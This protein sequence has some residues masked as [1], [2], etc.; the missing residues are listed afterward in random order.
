MVQRESKPTVL[1]S[2]EYYRGIKSIEFEP[3]K[4]KDFSDKLVYRKGDIR[5]EKRFFKKPKYITVTEDLYKYDGHLVNAKELLNTYCWSIK[6][7]EEKDFFYYPAEVL[8]RFDD[9]NVCHK[10]DTDEEAEEFVKYLREKCAKCGNEL[11]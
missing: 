2:R 10:F 5:T 9:R 6:Y 11:L 1:K 4:I 7:N 8:I 3:L